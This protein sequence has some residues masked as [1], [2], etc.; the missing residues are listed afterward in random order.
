MAKRN[1]IEHMSRIVGGIM[2]DRRVYQLIGFP[3]ENGDY[4]SSIVRCENTLLSVAKA[5]RYY[6]T[7]TNDDIRVV[8]ALSVGEYKSWGAERSMVIRIA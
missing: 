8:N 2:S 1:N 4:S 3:D 6:G 5:M 7:F